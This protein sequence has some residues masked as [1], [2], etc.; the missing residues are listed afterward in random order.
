ETVPLLAQILPGRGEDHARGADRVREREQEQAAA[1]DVFEEATRR[2]GRQREIR[3]VGAAVVDVHVARAAA[4]D[5]VL[6]QAI[7]HVLHIV[8]PGPDDDAAVALFVPAE[9]RDVVLRPVEDRALGGGRGAGQAGR[10][11]AHLPAV[12]FDQPLQ[13]RAVPLL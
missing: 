3:T 2:L 4:Q 1:A 8:R 6:R 9:G 11:A 10:I 12:T 7:A 13:A 5:A